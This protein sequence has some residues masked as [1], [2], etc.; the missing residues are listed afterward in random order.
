MLKLNY[1]SLTK[2]KCKPFQVEAT[3]SVFKKVLH[4]HVYIHIQN[5]KCSIEE[6]SLFSDIYFE[7]YQKL[8]RQLQFLNIKLV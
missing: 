1:N 4:F 8:K 2:Q 5:I 6:H 7:I 3:L